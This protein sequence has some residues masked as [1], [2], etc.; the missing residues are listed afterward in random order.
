MAEGYEDKVYDVIIMGGGPAG[1]T[2]AA[3]LR[4]HGDLSVAVFEREFFPREHIGES[5]SH[6][7]IPV[8]EESGALEKVLASDCWVKKYGGYYAWD[9]AG[10]PASTYFDPESYRKDGSPRW[11]F[12]C[13][14]SEL[15]DIL[16]RHAGS[17]GAEGDSDDVGRLMNRV[18]PSR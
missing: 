11:S 1:A 2:L 4:R 17:V 15:D 13:N 3:L 5:F 9:P 12:H 7:V 8:L 10:D 18:A 16:L 6:R 14:R